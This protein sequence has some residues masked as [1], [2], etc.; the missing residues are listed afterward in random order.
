MVLLKDIMKKMLAHEIEFSDAMNAVKGI[1]EEFLKK[2]EE[3]NITE[4]IPMIE[5]QR[6]WSNQVETIRKMYQRE[7]T[8][9]DR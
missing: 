4:L 3:D 5:V 8:R 7:E 2:I 9:N 6:I 1:K